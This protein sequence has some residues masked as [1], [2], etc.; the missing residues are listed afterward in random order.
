MRVFLSGVSC[1]GKTTIGAKLAD[2]LNYTFFDL[3]KEIESYFGT[4]IE[5]LQNELLT[6][7]AFRKE[8]SKALKHLLSQKKSENCV[9]AL[10]PSGLMDNYWHSVEKANGTIVFVDDSPDN[11]LKRAIFY[12]IDSNLIERRLT[13][14]EERKCL[15]LIKEDIAYFRPSYKKAH[16]T[17][18]IRGLGIGESALK[19]KKVLKPY[20][21]KKYDI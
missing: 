20:L 21:Q 17:V 14:K 8:A 11:I 1:V 5:R 16:F 3:D 2:L 18:D 13:D 12:D 7:Y 6:M 4:S 9:I 19:V 15:K 10:P